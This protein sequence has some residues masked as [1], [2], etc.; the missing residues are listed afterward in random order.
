MEQLAAEM[1]VVSDSC[2]LQAGVAVNGSLDPQGYTALHLAAG[3]GHPDVAQELL[4]KGADLTAR[5]KFLGT[6]L[7]VALSAPAA[8]QGRDSAP[9]QV[10]V[11]ALL[12]K[13]GADIFE[14]SSPPGHAV[15]HYAATR[16]NSVL[17]Q[18]LLAAGCSVNQ[19]DA[20]GRTLL[21]LA[22]RWGNVE[23]VGMLLAHGAAV[24]VADKDGRTALIHAAVSKQTAVVQQLLAAGAAA[25]AVS[26]YGRTVLHCLVSDQ[27]AAG[28][29]AAATGATQS[30]RHIMQLLINSGADVNARDHSGWTP[31]HL[32]AMK[33][34]TAAAALLLECG[35]DV[36]AMD[37]CGSSSLQVAALSRR[38]NV[39]QVLLDA[40]AE[41]AGATM[42]TA[43][44][45]K[46]M[47]MIKLLLQ[48]RSHPPS[49]D[50]VVE[51][52]V[53]VL[54]QQQYA[55]N[56]NVLATLLLH[57]CL[58]A[59]QQRALQPT[60]AVS[61]L[62][63][64]PSVTAVNKD[65]PVLS[66]ALLCS[67]GQDTAEVDAAQESLAAQEKDLA[68]VKTA[69]QQT[70]WQLAAADR[71]ASSAPQPAATT[72]AAA[73]AG[74]AAVTSAAASPAAPAAVQ[75]AAAPRRSA[76]LRTHV[77]ATAATAAAAA[78]APKLRAAKRRAR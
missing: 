22:V 68:T 69:A 4:A 31:L 20:S 74:A 35:A 25:T 28:P 75:P 73:A 14:P 54:L 48:H 77:A 64:R 63:S 17:L 10:A 60:A 23:A 78:A 45:T 15:A 55:D 43:V 44:M 53:C 76:R 16:G 18:R 33:G 21:H 3:A 1:C 47:P 39:A 11:A 49:L 42:N 51:G 52:F 50:T 5:H 57:F 72:A 6:P 13:A 12:L 46:H 30:L 71:A 19:Q 26:K 41:V 59:Q 67:W 2:C 58:L 7:R 8:A 9:G 37:S 66:L 61:D 70:Y 34:S 27:C 62:F 40:G 36:N 24:D 65:R 32:A 38:V 29:S 56:G